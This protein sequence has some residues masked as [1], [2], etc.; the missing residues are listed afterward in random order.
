MAGKDRS[1]PGSSFGSCQLVSPCIAGGNLAPVLTLNSVC[2]SDKLIYRPGQLPQAVQMRHTHVLILSSAFVLFFCVKVARS[3]ELILSHNVCQ[4][5]CEQELSA[6]PVPDCE[7]AN[8]L[9]F[10]D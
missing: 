10:I 6:L 4:G 5:K 1:V 2:A 3:L 8:V 7:M 9:S